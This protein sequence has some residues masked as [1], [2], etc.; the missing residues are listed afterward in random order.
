MDTGGALPYS[1]FR[2]ESMPSFS[3]EFPGIKRQDSVTPSWI[4]LR[5]TFSD[6]SRLEWG[7]LIIGT[8]SLLACIGL[9][10]ERLDYL[11]PGK[12][13]HNLSILTE[14]QYRNE[15]KKCGA[16]FT[17][18]LLILINCIFCLFHVWHGI[19]W[20]RPY[21]L[22][23][24]AGSILLVTIYCIVDF[25]VNV[26]QG[27]D[28][29]FNF[30]IKLARLVILLVLGGLDVALGCWIAAKFLREGRFA[31]RVV[32]TYDEVIQKKCK[33]HFF[34]QS[35]L[36]FDLEFQITM[37]VLI[38]RNGFEFHLSDRELG[39]L[40]T[41]LVIAVMWLAAVLISLRYEIKPL[42]WIV[43]GTSVLE[44]AYIIYKIYDSADIL[45]TDYDYTSRSLQYCVFIG[46]SI[47]III[48]I[49]LTIS[50]VLTYRT[51]GEGLNERIYGITTHS[52]RLPPRKNTIEPNESIN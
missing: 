9:T 27:M 35:L 4:G 33:L 22:H 40:I 49:L 1:I 15:D 21:E 19:V 18:A 7:F 42:S 17:F 45:K 13:P 31:C 25:A 41:G 34:T 50:F 8:T 3:M 38:L 51:F 48:R 30:S 10:I 52:E 32:K 36:T 46:G 14:E 6:V 23:I 44:P 20:E 28:S 26:Q 37:V 43:M 16:E 2:E 24:F 12:C 11:S 47:G 5:R 29:G 39:I